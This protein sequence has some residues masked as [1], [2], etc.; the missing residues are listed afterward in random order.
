MNNQKIA[1]ELNKVAKSL[2]SWDDGLY[3]KLAKMM[4]KF[5]SNNFAYNG[6][7]EGIKFE[8]T[9]SEEMVFCINFISSGGKKLSAADIESFDAKGLRIVEKNLR[10]CGIV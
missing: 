8:V 7:W 5:L 9:I 10:K 6:K 1:K 2:V 4:Q 3:K